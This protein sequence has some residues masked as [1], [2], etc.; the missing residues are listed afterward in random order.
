[1]LLA[2]AAV[3]KAHRQVLPCSFLDGAID[4]PLLLTRDYNDQIHCLANVCTHRG[5]LLC[6]GAGTE[7]NLRCRYH[8]RRF[9]LNGNM[10]SMPEFEGVTNFPSPSDNLPKV[11]HATWS[12]FLFASLNPSASLNELFAPM[13]SRLNFLP[14]HQFLPDPTR[15]REY[16]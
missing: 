5:N 15:H 14:I 2:H 10:I 11:P 8:G 9:D 3:L 12:R 7:K 13:I 4:E 16:T 1:M 6:E